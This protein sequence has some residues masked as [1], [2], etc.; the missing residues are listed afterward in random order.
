M[1]LREP[2]RAN[3]LRPGPQVGESA[4]RSVGQALTRAEAHASRRSAPLTSAQFRALGRLADHGVNPL[5]R[6]SFR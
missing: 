4:G 5:R 1:A 6:T 2:K 3:D